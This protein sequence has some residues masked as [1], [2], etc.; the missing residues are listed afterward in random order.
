MSAAHPDRLPDTSLSLR[1]REVAGLLADGLRTD[2]V[3]WTLRISLT[4]VRTHIKNAMSK[5]DLHSR[6]QL[7]EWVRVRRG[8][9]G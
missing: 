1:E 3:A 2:Q 4:T 7:V 6:R 9:A 8:R 5:R